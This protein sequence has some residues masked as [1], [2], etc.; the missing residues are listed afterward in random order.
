[1]GDW[2]DEEYIDSLKE[3]IFK[4][5]AERD[6][7]RASLV[8]CAEAFE[9]LSVGGGINAHEYAAAIRKELAYKGE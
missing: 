4:L 6:A 5:R 8:E 2:C 9:A 1:M 7:L 3:E